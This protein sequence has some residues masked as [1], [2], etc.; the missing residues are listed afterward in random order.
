MINMPKSSNLSSSNSS[1]YDD[2]YSQ[3]ITSSFKEKEK[4]MEIEYKYMKMK[5]KSDSYCIIM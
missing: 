4:K 3:G 1:S 2:L 5:A